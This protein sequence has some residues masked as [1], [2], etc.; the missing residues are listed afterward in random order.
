ME[1]NR[2]T[3]VVLPARCR[4]TKVACAWVD[5]VDGTKGQAWGVGEE[6]GEQKEL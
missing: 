5:V 2:W 4:G 6:W 1:A 3:K